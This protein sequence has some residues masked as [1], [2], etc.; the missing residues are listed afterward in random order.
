VRRRRARQRGQIVPLVALLMVVLTGFAALAIDSGVAYDQSRTDQDVS[1]SA[2]LAAGY[3]IYSHENTQGATLAQAFTAALNVANR[4][5]TGPSAPC[6]LTVNFY[7]S[8]PSTAT[9]TASVQSVENPTPITWVPSSC[10]ASLSSIGDTGASV[11]S[12]GYHYLSSPVTKAHT[13]SIG[14]QAVVQVVGGTGSG[15]SDL[16][17]NCVLC[18]L[19]GQGTYQ[20]TG[21]PGMSLPSTSDTDGLNLTTDGANISVNGGFDCER[22]SNDVATI[23]TKPSSG[24]ST[25]GTVDI[26][27][28]YTDNC[29]L[30]WEPA[31][32]ASPYNPTTGTT[33][34]TDPLANMIMPNV[35]TYSSCTASV[36]ITSNTTLQPGCYGQI[37]I[38]GTSTGGSQMSGG[39]TCVS[40]GDGI[41]VMFDSGTGGT[42]GLYIIYGGLTIEGDDPTVES[43]VCQ[44]SK[45]GVTLDFVCSTSN[46]NGTGKP[47]PAS[48]NASGQTG[49]ELMI[50]TYNLSGG[51]IASCD[52]QYLDRNNNLPCDYQWNLFPPETGEWANI[53][54]LYDRNNIAPI[55]TASQTADPDSDHNGAIYAASATYI[56]ANYS[57]TNTP[58]TTTGYSCTTPLGAPVIVDYL[59]VDANYTA[60]ACQDFAWADGTF[61]YQL[62]NDVEV[63]AGGPGGIVS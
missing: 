32:T 20:R 27:G 19:A 49:A 11:G 59:E 3:W 54:I 22:G 17:L 26:A 46:Y 36:T 45:G 8:Y 6:S 28:T 7:G 55:E 4:D 2:A 47:G 53:V 21:V 40:N 25:T 13:F 37:T 57:S 14:D 33:P 52:S 23:D 51:G 39:Q 60:S 42:D 48:C 5:C 44:S 30:T 29:S 43:Q 1:D 63:P 38:D 9:C 18:I 24:G 15:N 61:V 56:M 35:A 58:S 12:T 34:I 50:D 62:D 31:S 41:D 10:T 16:Y